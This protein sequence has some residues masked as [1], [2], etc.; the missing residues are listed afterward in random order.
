MTPFGSEAQGDAWVDRL[1]NEWPSSFFGGKNQSGP[2][3]FYEK[4]GKYFVDMEL[5][6][7]E[8]DDVSISVKHNVLTISGNK[9]AVHEEKDVHYHMRETTHGSF[10]RSIRL[11][12]DV[13]EDKME[14]VY[15]NGILHLEIPHT[16]ESKVKKIEI[17]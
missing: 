15:K 12:D 9:K 6:G 2:L 14:A 10:S 16:S 17:H 11:P 7:M 1:W 8:K 5:P 3:D 13:E 4:D